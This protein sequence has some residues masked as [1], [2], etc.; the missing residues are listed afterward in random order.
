MVSKIDYHPRPKRSTVHRSS[1]YLA[2]SFLY[3]SEQKSEL[4]ARNHTLKTIRAQG[5]AVPTAPSTQVQPTAA[6]L[7]CS[8]S[9]PNHNNHGSPL[10]LVNDM[11]HLVKVVFSPFLSS[12]L[13]LEYISHMHNQPLSFQR[14][15]R[16]VC[17]HITALCLT[18]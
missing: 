6:P 16:F 9:T 8:N 3:F 10:T 17:R 1:A 13:N 5:L 11:L 4:A 15:W 14:I 7:P 18:F 12:H 2:Y